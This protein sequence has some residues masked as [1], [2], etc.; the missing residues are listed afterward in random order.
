MGIPSDQYPDAAS[1]TS[2]LDIPDGNR[3]TYVEFLC[4]QS[5]KFPS[6]WVDEMA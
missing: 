3:N 5:L 6:N 4:A 1:T 2:L